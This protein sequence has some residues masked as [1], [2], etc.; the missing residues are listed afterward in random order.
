MLLLHLHSVQFIVYRDRRGL[1][2]I[3]KFH[4]AARIVKVTLLQLQVDLQLHDVPL[5]TC[6]T[7]NANNMQ[8][9]ADIVGDVLEDAQKKKLKMKFKG[10]EVMEEVTV[11]QLTRPIHG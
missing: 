2:T 3:R 9:M 10:R 4:C 6:D 1:A 8:Q 7:K 11:A 5:E